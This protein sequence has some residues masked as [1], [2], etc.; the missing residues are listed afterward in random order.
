MCLIIEGIRKIACKGEK[1]DIS[2]S[3]R[4]KIKVIA[5]NFGRTNPNECEIYDDT[6]CV[7]AGSLDVVKRL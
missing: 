2:C 7:Y 5:A 4:T 1:L 3:H 6:I